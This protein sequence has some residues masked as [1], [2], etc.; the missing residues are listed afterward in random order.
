MKKINLAEVKEAAD[1]RLPAGGYI[2]KYT[3]VKDVPEKEYLYMEYDIAKGEYAGYYLGLSEKFNFW[4]GKCYRSYKENALSMFKRMCSAVS[5]SNNGYVFDGDTNADEQTLTGKLVGL[6]LCEE[7]Y[8]GND[9]EVKTRLYV[10][11][12]CPVEDIING[13]FKVKPIKR[14]EGSNKTP[15][16]NAADFVGVPAGEDN[17]LPF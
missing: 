1:G 12:E 10:D 4:G 16:P 17:S 5:K 13:K 14:L 6:V 11:R 3:M 7:E 8:V 9:G 2:C 15:A